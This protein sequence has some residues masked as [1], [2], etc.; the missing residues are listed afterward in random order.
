MK[1][2]ETMA[3]FIKVARLSEVARNR[4]L[5]LSLEGEDILLLNVG[6]RIYAINNVCPHQHF[7]ALH[8]GSLEEREITCPVHGSTF[9]IQTGKSIGD[10]GMLTCYA[11]KLEGD[12]IYIERPWNVLRSESN[13]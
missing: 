13:L 3:E 10:G 1:R 8:E 5:L 11:V 12:A 6:G 4:R 7:S 9:D 2:L